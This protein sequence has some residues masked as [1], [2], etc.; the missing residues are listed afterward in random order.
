MTEFPFVG[1][2]RWPSSAQHNEIQ[3]ANISS[4]HNGNKPQHNEISTTQRNSHNTTEMLPTT[5]G[6]C[7]HWK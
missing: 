4:Q 1:K 5:R 7:R 6:Q 2:L 3:K